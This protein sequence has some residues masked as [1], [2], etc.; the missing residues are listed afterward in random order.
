M[1]AYPPTGPARDQWVLERRPSRNPVNPHRPYASLLE[2]ERSHGGA[3]VDVAT[4]FLTGHECP[5]RCLM[6]DLWKNTTATPTPPG[7]IPEQI[8][9]ALHELAREHPNA[10]LRQLKLYN[11]GSFFDRAAVPPEDFEA[12]ARRA[13]QFERVVVESHPALIGDVTFRFRDLLVS[14]AAGEAGRAMGSNVAGSLEANQEPELRACVSEADPP[15]L[16]VAIGLETA[17]P[18]VLE[19]LN[20]RVTIDDF[21]SAADRLRHEGIAL[22]VF[23]LIQPPFT[24]EAD[25]V[26]WAKHSTDFAFDCGASV[27]SLI[28]TRSGNG[29]LEALAGMGLFA[30]PPLASLEAVLAYG[31]DLRRGRVFADLWDLEKF[32]RCPACFAAR[33]ARLEEMNLNQRVPP[34]VPCKCQ[35]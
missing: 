15:I 30:P 4:V 7:A 1:Q 13:R 16:E 6:C 31:I 23:V 27:V 11:S 10:R 21:A 19:K 14:A 12:I 3:V 20:K 32:S 35:G 34:P 22:R 9:F 17:N 25:A 5:W 26:E 29:A 2:R 18:A 28:P 33:R 8:E 24:N